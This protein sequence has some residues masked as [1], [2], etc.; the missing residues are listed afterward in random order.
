MDGWVQDVRYAARSLVRSRSHAVIATLTLAL[1]IGVNTAIFSLVNQIIFLDLPMEQPDELAWVWS[2]NQSIA[3]DINGLSVPDFQDLRE[4]AR[5]FESLAAFVQEPAVLSGLDDPERITIAR[6]STNLM[7]VWGTSPVLGRGFV[8]GEEL[9]G[10]PAVT[11]I[12][13]GMWVN[14]FGS[15]P[16]VLGRTLRLD[17]VEH[18]IIGVADPRMETGNLGVA[19]ALVPLPVDRSGAGRDERVALVTGRLR[20]GVSLADARAEVAS[21]GRDLEA[22]HPDANRG[23]SLQAR[24]TR[25]S[26]LGDEI[27]SIMILLSLTVVLVLLIACANVANLVLVRASG[28]GR[29]LAVRSALGAGRSRLVRQL[30]T[31]NTMVALAAGVIGLGLA[32]ALLAMLVRITRG[33]QVLFTIAEV[34]GRVLLFTLFVSL[35]APLIFGL[36]PAVGATR[37][38]VSRSL[39][40]GGARTGASRRTGRVRG[41]LVTAQITLA[42]SLMVVAGLISR[43]VIALQALDWGFRKD[44][45]LTLVVELPETKYD[46]DGARQFFAEL[47]RRTA[48]LPGV[49]G[50]A[51]ASARPQPT[52]SGGTRFAIESRGAA[53]PRDLPSAYTLLITPDWFDV[54]EVPIV[55]GRGIEAG[56]TEDRT[57]VV[58]INRLAAER[59]WPDA[60]PIDQRIR[61]GG[62]A[63]APWLRV[64]GITEGTVAGNDI[65]NPEAPQIFLPFAQSPAQSMVLMARTRGKP[66]A[67]V[68][69]I[70]REVTAIDPD[71]PI[72]DVRTMSEFIYDLNAV[73]YALGTL[74]T[75]FSLFA[76]VMAAMGI[77][78]VM[79]YMV[80]QRAREISLRMALGAER[81]DVLRMVLVRGGRLIL[82]GAVLGIGLAWLLS[83]LIAG[84]IYGVS[85]TDPVSFLGIPAVLALIAFAANYIPAFRATRITPMSAMRQD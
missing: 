42:L 24:S 18:T 47:E 3:S 35:L 59:Y 31:E 56:D 15:D 22:E 58:V 40:E 8:A 71:Q 46:G 10:A 34:D 30:L 62:D 1:G 48:A 39:R 70:R 49:E 82:V 37:A 38:D 28:R 85:P 44:G 69:P 60:D 52:L 17:G 5:S 19:R 72:D 36:W 74:F 51:L 54:L 84:L 21:I 77:Y 16:G 61:I 29:E 45:L 26:V 57:P 4:R 66:A 33:R 64:V 53:E 13:H 83:R 43:S 25:D 63:D 65:E 7:E 41:V 79:S 75:V 32:R 78:G 81:R 14:R 11:V 67:L 23:W 27:T 55:R 73:G 68:D 6:T 12:T 20:P 9:A 2:V 76:L 80:S 50:V